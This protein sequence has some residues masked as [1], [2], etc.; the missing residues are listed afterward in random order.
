MSLIVTATGT[1]VGKTIVSAMILARFAPE[2]SDGEAAKPPLVYWKPVASGACEGRD[3]EMVAR[4]TQGRAVRVLEE[5]Y[6][7]Q[8]PLSPHVA[9]RLE[10][11]SIDPGK[12]KEDWL[13]LQ[14]RHRGSSF[15]VEGIGGLLV[16]LTDDGY[17]AADL[18]RE[19]ELPVLVVALSTLGTINH[20]LLTLEAIR[21]RGMVLAGVVLNGPPNEENRMAIERFGAAAV[22]A[23]VDRIEP[24]NRETLGAAAR[25]FDLDGALQARLS[26]ADAG[27]PNE[28]DDA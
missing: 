28:G 3:T 15:V 13:D 17:L 14:A 9:A 7:H 11:C 19:L 16:P 10:G 21:R 18:F 4:L 5:S 20:T 25:R 23:E 22:V 8:A 2:A 1:E 26:A 24:L 27:P 12:L 6:L